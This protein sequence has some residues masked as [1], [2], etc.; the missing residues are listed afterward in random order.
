MGFQKLPAESDKAEWQRAASQLAVGDADGHLHVLELPKN[1]VRQGN[2]SME[3]EGEHM[4][5]LLRRY[6]ASVE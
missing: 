1:L 5:F 3:A 4:E 2:Q 6:E